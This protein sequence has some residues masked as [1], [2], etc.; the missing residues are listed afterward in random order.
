M[1]KRFRRG[2]QR[3]SL[4]QGNIVSLA[5]QLYRTK[6]NNYVVTSLLAH[7]WLFLLLLA[8]FIVGLFS[9]SAFFFTL[10]QTTAVFPWMPFTILVVGG[11]LAWPLVFSRFTAAGGL[12]SRQM[13]WVLRGEQ[14]D[15]ATARAA[16]FPR[17]FDY[18]IAGLIVVLLLLL[19]LL[20]LAP[21]TYWSGY[22]WTLGVLTPIFVLD[23]ALPWVSTVKVL[24]LILTGLLILIPLIIFSYFWV[25]L[26]LTDVIL[27]I[28]PG[29]TPS[30][31]V[32]R[33]WQ[34]T[35]QQAFHSLTVLFIC[36]VIILAGGILAQLLNIVA[37][38]LVGA[39][40]N[41]F[42]FPFW[43][44]TKT[45]LYYDLRCRNEGLNFDLQND[46]PSPRQRLRRVTI[47]TPESIELDFAL[48]GVGSRVLAWIIDQVILLLSWTLISLLLLY[49]YENLL[50]P[51]LEAN[52][53]A[54]MNRVGQWIAAIY[55][56]F[57]F[58]LFN[59]YFIIF[60]TAW[61][62]QTPGKRIAEIR[63]VQDNGQPIRLPQAA[64]R[65]LMN[66]VDLTVFFIGLILVI[67]SRSEKR[68]GDLIAGTL[69]IQDESLA[70]APQP[71]ALRTEEITPASKALAHRLLAEDNLKNVTA[72]QYFTLRNFIQQRNQL[73][74]RVRIQTAAK[75]ADQLL[76]VVLPT[77]PV[78]PT[79]VIE[80]EFLM[81]VYLAYRRYHR[82]GLAANG[83]GSDELEF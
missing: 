44:G 36:N 79:E 27:G 56:L 61:Q 40:F 81:A 33:S 18:G 5:L 71:Q 32:V 68:L 67:F 50:G 69:V 35:R 10:L 13:F 42:T 54:A 2:N 22:A 65:S 7:L 70:T 77:A 83:N 45:G 29:V 14:E 75:L 9:L 73:S 8:L 4:S 34:I 58:A 3:S 47:Q 64:L 80:E 30:K 26:S 66:I 25:R 17:F 24:I 57:T 78:L 21:I 20:V 62:G 46:T 43:Q 60:E 76:P 1:L 48:G 6:G 23:N 74:P 39:F 37:T 15:L 19:V 63:V 38:P 11:C 52:F 59:G 72:D 51:A 12:I 31:S 41:V 53:P 49:L 28:E 82:S 16:V 55:G